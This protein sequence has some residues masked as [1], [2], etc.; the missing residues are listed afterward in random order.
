MFDDELKKYFKLSQ[1]TFSAVSDAGEV[2]L[3]NKDGDENILL[4][5]GPPGTIW[6]ATCKRFKKY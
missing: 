4:T 1:R 6:H 2:F 3:F 5:F